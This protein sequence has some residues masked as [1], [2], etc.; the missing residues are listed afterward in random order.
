MAVQESCWRLHAASVRKLDFQL[1]S[2][3]FPVSPF[4]A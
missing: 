2:N 1:A 4:G 3:L